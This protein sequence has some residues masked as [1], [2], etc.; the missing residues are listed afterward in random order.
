MNA[1]SSL[2]AVQKTKLTVM[3]EKGNQFSELNNSCSS[4]SLND[5]R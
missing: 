3:K 2:I 5:L 1:T 4:K